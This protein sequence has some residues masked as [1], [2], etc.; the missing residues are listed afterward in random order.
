MTGETARNELEP[1]ERF[2]WSNAIAIAGGGLVGMIAGRFIGPFIA[3]AIVAACN[4]WLRV[5]ERRAE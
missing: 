3:A 5:N 4:Y 2:A 1:G